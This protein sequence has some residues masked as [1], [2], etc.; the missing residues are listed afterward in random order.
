[1]SNQNR[2]EV[3]SW[4]LERAPTG[5][6]FSPDSRFVHAYDGRA[7]YTW[8]VPGFEEVHRFSIDEAERSREG[9]C[10]FL[11]GG[12]SIMLIASDDNSEE[13]IHHVT[14]RDL[15]SHAPKVE[16]D[17]RIEH[18]GLMTIL[19]NRVENRLLLTDCGG[20]SH[21]LEFPSCVRRRSVMF[22]PSTFASRGAA[23]GSK[24][25]SPD[26]TELWEVCGYDEPS[27]YREY[28]TAF[29]LNTGKGIR[30]R[31]PDGGDH[32]DGVRL[33]PDADSLLVVE[34]D[35]LRL[36]E[37]ESWEFLRSIDLAGSLR[38]GWGKSNPAIA[39]TANSR[40]LALSC[41]CNTRVCVAHFKQ[42]KLIGVFDVDEDFCVRFLSFSPDGRFL[43]IASYDMQKEVKLWDMSRILAR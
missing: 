11:S 23:C 19:F 41:E 39:F 6:G 12:E 20:T 27:G 28:L 7:I 31:P 13:G 8:S 30:R 33:S 2:I 1:M 17:I 40:L 25:F 10:R 43:A 16:A 38:K 26:E 29:D 3:A 18:Y 37:P 35:A 34:E 24:T 9:H 32:L 21:L 42:A 22:D 14:V 36:R 15:E 4:K 5:I